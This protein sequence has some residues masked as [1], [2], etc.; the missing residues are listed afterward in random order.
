[1]AGIAAT[2]LL[3]TQLS[4]VASARANVRTLGVARHSSLKEI[5]AIH[6]KNLPLVG[7]AKPNQPIRIMVHLPL[8]DKAGA[9]KLAASMATPKSPNYHKWLTRQQFEERFGPTQ[10]DLRAASDALKSAGFTVTKVDSQFVHAT[11][12]S[13][14]IERFFSTRMGIVR[15]IKGGGRLHVDART[16]I[17]MPAALAKLNAT[18]IGLRAIG[19]PKPDHQLSGRTMSARRPSSGARLRNASAGPHGNAYSGQLGPYFPGELY[20]AY[21][22]SSQTFANGAGETIGIVGYSDTLDSDNQQDWCYYGLGPNCAFGNST[23]AP[24]P[25]VHHIVFPGSIPANTDGTSIEASLDAQMAGGSAP[26][27]TID[28]Y[29]ADAVSNFGFLDA[30]SY[31]AFADVD[32]IITTSYSECELDYLGDDPSAPFY[33]LQALDDT[34][35]QGTV[36]GQTWLFSSGDNGAY[37]CKYEGIDDV[38]TSSLA[39]DPNVTAVGGTTSLNTTFLDGGYGTGYGTETSYSSP[40]FDGGWGSGGGFSQLFAPPTNQTLIGVDPGT[41]NPTYGLPYGTGRETPDVSMQMGGPDSGPFSAAWIYSGLYGEY[42]GLIGTSSSSPEM[43]GW[44]ANLLNYANA[45]SSNS[46]GPRLGNANE[47]YYAIQFYGYGNTGF[48][49]YIPGDNLYY[50]YYPSYFDGWGYNP[51]IGL[52]TPNMNQFLF[53]FG[54]LPD[55]LSGYPAAGDTFTASNP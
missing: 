11:A 52:G 46:V 6:A 24:Y 35:V 20:Q 1:V 21:G 42:I 47:E 36:Q 3:A 55:G 51:V 49:Q 25:V 45:A 17:R 34:F 32:D 44:L 37:G 28:M 7:Y 13:S 9:I 54:F 10:A 19:M 8:R 43:A 31:I 39:S 5:E 15:D 41:V 2:A 30:Y 4:S 22:Q 26:G 53:L 48:N 12:P 18:V 50:A 38:A 23:L 40:D 14:T 29:A 33:M 16:P 27:A